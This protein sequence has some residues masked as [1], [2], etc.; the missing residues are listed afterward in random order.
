MYSWQDGQYTVLIAKQLKYLYFISFV[1]CFYDAFKLIFGQ[2]HVFSLRN[3]LNTNISAFQLGHMKPWRYIYAL[4]NI[5]IITTIF[6]VITNQSFTLR[7][8]FHLQY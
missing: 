5:N 4:I 6:A 3:I 8:H 2:I 7:L 1:P